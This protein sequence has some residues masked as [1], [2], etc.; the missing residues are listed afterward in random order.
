MDTVNKIKAQV[1][2]LKNPAVVPT[3]YTVAVNDFS[4]DLQC[5]CKSGN[6]VQSAADMQISV[7]A[8]LESLYLSFAHFYFILSC[9]IFLTFQIYW[10]IIHKRLS[11]TISLITRYTNNICIAYQFTYFPISGNTS[12]HS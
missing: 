3:S 12:M 4:V 5:L 8:Y 9:F 2:A 10:K 1:A 6:N 11:D 7:V